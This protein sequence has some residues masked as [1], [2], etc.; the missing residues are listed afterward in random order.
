MNVDVA[1]VPFID[2]SVLNSRPFREA[3]SAIRGRAAYREVDRRVVY[4]DPNP[5]PAGSAAHHGMP[6]FFPTLKG[7]LS[8]IPLS[9]PVT[10]E[11]GWIAQFNEQV[12]RLRA[13]VDSARPH[14]R[15][16]V[17]EVMAIDR[18]EPDQRGPNSRLART[19]QY[20]GRPGR[21]FRIRGL[22]ASEARLGATLS[23]D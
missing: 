15:R 2:G 19:G 8:E 21:G 11:L 6:G 20:Q 12:R 18:E 17:A 4:V 3:I 23:V 14:I 22:R 16:L 7:A 13:I 9:Q 1:S 5:T 10:D